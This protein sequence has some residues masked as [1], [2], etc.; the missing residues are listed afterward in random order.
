MADRFD[1]HFHLIDPTLQQT[2]PSN[3]FFGFRRGIAVR[4][5]QK[6]VNRWTKMFFTAEGSDPLH[7]KFGCQFPYLIG[8]NVETAAGLR[9]TI[10][11]AIEDVNELIKA[12][13]QTAIDLT[14][15]EKLATA[16]LFRFDVLRVDA[17]EFWVD[18]RALSGKRTQ[19]LIPYARP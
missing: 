10:E 9:D 12:I 6:L 7:R 19:A 3:F 5:I 16:S 1:F 14:A 13:D 17:I 15:D 8:G 18:I 4:G 11:T 2:G